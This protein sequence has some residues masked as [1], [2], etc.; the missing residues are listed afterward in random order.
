MLEVMRCLDEELRQSPAPDVKAY[1]VIRVLLDAS[2]IALEKGNEDPQTFDRA[3]L[4]EICDPKAKTTGRDPA[5]W[6]SSSMLETF[7]DA[8]MN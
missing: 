7:M 5:R 8:R 6:L 1:K 2:I 3:T 4:L